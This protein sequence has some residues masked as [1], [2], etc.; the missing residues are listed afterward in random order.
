[1]DRAPG[2]IKNGGLRV[3]QNDLKSSETGSKFSPARHFFNAQ[4]SP[5]DQKCGWP[6]HR[7]PTIL[8][9]GSAHFYKKMEWSFFRINVNLSE[10]WVGF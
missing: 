10:K 6:T 5:I 8:S 9:I 3:G 7:Y 1:M 2:F 4:I